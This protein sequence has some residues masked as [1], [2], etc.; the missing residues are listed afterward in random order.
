MT[1]KTVHEYEVIFKHLK[2][3]KGEPVTATWS[4]FQISS[5]PL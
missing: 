3:N 2:N 4:C 1:E 5:R